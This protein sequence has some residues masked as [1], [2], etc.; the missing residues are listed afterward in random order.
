MTN[1][2]EEDFDRRGLDY[3]NPK[4]VEVLPEHFQTDYPKLITL[5]ETYYEHMDSDGNVG[6]EIRQ[7]LRARDISG[8][9]LRL[10]DY[11][12]QETG[13]GISGGVF[14]DPREVAELF[15]DYFRIKGSLWSAKSFFRA[16]Y[17]E[18]VDIVYP[19]DNLFIV[20]DSDS[21]IGYE[22]LKF[23]QDGALYQTLSI[24]IRSSQSVSTWRELYK[25]YVHPAGYYLGGEVVISGVATVAGLA[26]GARQPDAIP[27]S[28]V[29]LREVEGGVG[30]L[31]LSAI[32]DPMSI[33]VTHPGTG[34]VQRLDAERNV[35][36]TDSATIGQIRAQYYNMY[37]F[38]TVDGPTADDSWGIND[39]GGAVGI[40]G[41]NTIETGDRGIWNRDSDSD[42]WVVKYADWQDRNGIWIDSDEWKD[43]N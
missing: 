27:D 6:D 18:E 43:A 21:K 40:T 15:P 33:L 17:G 13:G 11:L 32:S 4:I 12:L 25:K 16:L 10:L 3:R 29:N 24:L 9:S 39:T 14:D 8:V 41:D 31:A 2:F 37:D 28:D 5:L 36:I 34:E 7:I 42:R 35:G 26:F 19:K 38:A 20:G 22:S 1:R 30:I 23:I